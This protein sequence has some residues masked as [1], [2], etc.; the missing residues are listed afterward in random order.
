MSNDLIYQIALTRIPNIGDIHT[1]TL[2]SVF[3]NATDVFKAKR[4]Q[5]ECIPGLGSIR[6]NSILS[7]RNFSECER[8]IKFIEQYRIRPLFINGEDYPKRLLHCADAPILLY[9]RG[10][11]SLDHPRIV[12]IV[13][14]RNNSEHGKKVTEKI[15][16]ELSENDVLIISGLAYGIDTIAHRAALKNGLQTVGVLAHG[17]GVIYPEENHSLA[18]NMLKQGGL[19]T[20]FTGNTLP[21]RENFPKRNRVVAGLSDATIVI[22]SG[23]KGGSLITAGIADSYNRDVFA[24]PG[25][26]SD[27]KSSGCNQLIRTHRAQLVRNADD[28]LM[29][30]NWKPGPGKEKPVQRL[31][32]TNLDGDEKKVYEVLNQQGP[33]AIDLLSAESALSPGSL[34][35]I[36]LSLELKGIVSAQPGKVYSLI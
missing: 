15:I 16:H 34:A 26:P 23:V 36:L 21:A 5:L 2:V 29:A 30:M 12:A 20:E 33:L 11:A 13:G 19:L 3:G 31:L 10:N 17:M 8:E 18:R 9:Y 1:R 32:F 25:R 4:R 7:Y 14:T 6:V 27:E 35:S 22:E 24:V 28:I